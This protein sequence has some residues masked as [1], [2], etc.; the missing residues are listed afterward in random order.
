MENH[1]YK[2]LNRKHQH[3]QIECGSLDTANGGPA[4]CC[5]RIPGGNAGPPWVALGTNGEDIAFF[6]RRQDDF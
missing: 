3:P 2:H 1:P 6:G 5:K 4:V